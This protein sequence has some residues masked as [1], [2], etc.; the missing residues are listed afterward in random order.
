MKRCLL[1]LLLLG[2]MSPI[3]AQETVVERVWVATDKQ[4]YLAG[5][6]IHCAAFCVDAAGGLSSLNRVAYLELHSADGLAATAK[7]SLDGG[8]GGGYLD[9]PVSLPTGNYRLI[10]YTAQNRNEID[11]GFAGPAA[12]TLSVFNTQS[13]RR[14]K[15]GVEVVSAEEYERRRIESVRTKESA[16]REMNRG[17]LVLSHADSTLTLTNTSSY[18]LTLCLSITRDDGILPPAGPSLDTFMEMVH[19]LGPRQFE[20]RV[21]IDY[22]GE[23]VQARITGLNPQQMRAITGKSLF[24]STPSDQAEIYAAPVAGDGRVS[25]LTGNIYGFRE[26]ICQIEGAVLPSD[27]RIEFISPFAN[28][29]VT[30]P[31]SLVLSESIA[32]ALEARTARQQAERPKKDSLSDYLPHKEY[33][34]LDANPAVYPLDDYT[35]FNTLEETFIEFIPQVRVRQDSNR[36]PCIQVR[37]ED[38]IGT[39]AFAKEPAL[40]LLDGVPVFDHEKMLRYDPR[41]IKIIEVYPRT[42]YLGNY[43]FSGVVQCITQKR[44]LT[45]FKLD[46]GVKVLAFEGV[47][48]PTVWLG[49]G[50]WHPLVD[51]APGATCQFS[52]ILPATPGRYVVS[53]EGLTTE[54]CQP[55]HATLVIEK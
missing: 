52:G 1:F 4:V 40:I 37:L 41:L 50:F 10:A 12:R 53:V 3:A 31:A 30:G 55:V 8:R 51:L 5:E 19:T 44:N 2:V 38:V 17:L 16:S 33:L 9:L 34:L 15:D 29:P 28:A 7:L 26:M 23:V 20:N 11:Y 32:P 27:A 39:P 13:N 14:V 46:E 48:W 49:D 25:F 6:R 42:F 35:R 43:T 22:E 47:S 24:L 45:S 18:P 21:N 36:V 54:D